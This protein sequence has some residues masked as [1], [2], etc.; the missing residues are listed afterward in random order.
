MFFRTIGLLALLSL[1]LAVRVAPEAVPA[2]RYADRPP[3]AHTG[4]FGEPTCRACHFQHPLNVPGGTLVLDGLPEGYAPGE[5]YRLTVRLQREGMQRSGFELAV[6]FAEGPAVGRQAGTLTAADTTRATITRADAV[7]YV[8]HTVAGTALTDPNAAQWTLV[9][10]APDTSA[11]VIFH[12]VGNAA[13][14][15]ASAFG[16]FIYTQEVVLSGR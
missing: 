2:H 6:R 8:H 5:R 4:G 14:G 13:N 15:D 10:T 9:W 3:P 11:P 7:Q 1:G 12:A 16:D